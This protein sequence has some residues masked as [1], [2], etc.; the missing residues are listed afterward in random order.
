MFRG[1]LLHFY[2]YPGGA[3]PPPPYIRK[4]V[5]VLVREI[6]DHRGGEFRVHLRQH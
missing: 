6:H 1:R 4:Q 2:N 3:G 5:L